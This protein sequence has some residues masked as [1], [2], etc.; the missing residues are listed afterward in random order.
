M[1]KAITDNT[2]V[3]ICSLFLIFME[4]ASLYF[5]IFTADGLTDSSPSK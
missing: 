2:T 3:F 4:S 5:K 1:H